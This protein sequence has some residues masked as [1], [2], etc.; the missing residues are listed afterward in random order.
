MLIARRHT[1]VADS[2]PSRPCP[3]SIA[4]SVGG[5]PR[6]DHRA[7]SASSCG[8][9]YGLGQLNSDRAVPVPPALKFSSALMR[10]V[11]R[12][13]SIPECTVKDRKR[14]AQKITSFGT[15]NRQ[16]LRWHP[17]ASVIDRLRT[18]PCSPGPPTATWLPLRT[19]IEL[20]GVPPDGW[21]ANACGRCESRA[22]QCT[23]ECLHGEAI[24]PARAVG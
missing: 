16:C 9:R 18:L 12:S 24:T 21:C 13:V 15:L 4:R 22:V 17:I 5:C 7:I 19:T 11:L 1:A 2:H 14:Y 23:D 3:P 6:R 10:G 8:V 20:A